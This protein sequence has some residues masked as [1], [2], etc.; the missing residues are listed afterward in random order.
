MSIKAL[1]LDSLKDLDMGKAFVAFQ[2][3]L[4][5]AAADCIDRPGDGKARSV[6]LEIAL[7]P[8]IE[9]DGTCEEVRAQIAVSSKVPIHKTKVYS[10]GVRSNG[11]VTFNPDSPDNVSQGTFSMEG[12]ED[13]ND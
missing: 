11:A 6:K 13:N 8:V 9:P 4:T 2:Q 7:V 10:F 12:D 5:R 1:T 3:H